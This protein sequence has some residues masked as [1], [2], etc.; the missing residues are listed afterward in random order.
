MFSFSQ[1]AL[2][3][4]PPAENRA[5]FYYETAESMGARRPVTKWLL[6]SALV[7]RPPARQRARRIVTVLYIEGAAGGS[8]PAPC[9]VLCRPPQLCRPPGRRTMCVFSGDFFGDFRRILA[10]LVS[11]TPPDGI[12]EEPCALAAQSPPTTSICERW[13]SR[14]NVIPTLHW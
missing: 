9:L 13:H 5:L 14:S 10:H 1:G 8:R 11:G 4:V 7:R 6:K 12:L 2:F 3:H